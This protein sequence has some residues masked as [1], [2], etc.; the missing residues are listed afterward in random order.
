MEIAWKLC[1]QPLIVN[2]RSHSPGGRSASIT[3]FES[4]M[5]ESLAS[6]FDYVSVSTVRENEGS[7]ERCERFSSGIGSAFGGTSG[8]SLFRGLSFHLPQGESR[9]LLVAQERP[10]S[11]LGIIGSSP[12]CVP[13]SRGSSS[14]YCCLPETNSTRRSGTQYQEDIGYNQPYIKPKLRVFISLVFFLIL[15]ALALKCIHAATYQNGFALILWLF[16]G[17]TSFVGAQ[18]AFYLALES[19]GVIIGT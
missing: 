18:V 9:G 11:Y 4:E 7:L 2:V 5:Q 16:G 10:V 1:C 14:G 12:S 17:I 6:R 13:S 3:P 19:L 15:C 8:T